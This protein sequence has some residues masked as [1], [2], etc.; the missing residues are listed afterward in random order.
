MP[1]TSACRVAETPAAR[2][3]LP[4][5][6]APSSTLHNPPP[7]LQARRPGPRSGAAAGAAGP[8]AQQRR[9]GRAELAG[10]S[11]G[12]SQRPRRQRLLAAEGRQASSCQ[13]YGGELRQSS[14][15]CWAHVSSPPRP[16]HFNSFPL[17]LSLFCGRWRLYRS[18]ALEWYCA[19]YSD[20]AWTDGGSGELRA[21]DE[22][23]PFLSAEPPVLFQTPCA[24]PCSAVGA[25]P[26]LPQGHLCPSAGSTS[27]LGFCAL[28]VWGDR[29]G[30]GPSEEA[31]ERAALFV[32]QA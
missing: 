24:A 28:H 11:A 23:R 10:A 9:A 13:A 25:A 2:A 17:H 22:R 14:F 32:K 20:D 27:F 26:S 16:Q 21:P 29:R 5:A 15:P 3:L 1:P 12:S 8:A 7:V 6:P 4:T 30:K 18:P 31:L 19:R